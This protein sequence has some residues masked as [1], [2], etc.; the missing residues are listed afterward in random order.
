M[1]ALTSQER[2]TVLFLAGLALAGMVIEVCVKRNAL[3]SH[4]AVVAE[5]FGKV[6]LN[7]ADSAL[8]CSVPGIGKKLA[9]RI[10]EARQRR[11]CFLRLEELRQIKGITAARYDKIKAHLVVR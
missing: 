6:D 5:D 8:L 11:I 2:K 9:E 10:I 1:W 3:I 4:L 7:T